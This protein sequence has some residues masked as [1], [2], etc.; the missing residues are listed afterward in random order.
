MQNRQLNDFLVK[1]IAVCVFALIL[2]LAQAGGADLQ[3]TWADNSAD[4]GGFHIERREATVAAYSR[5]ATVPPNTTSYTD[6]G[7]SDGKSFC[8]R[9]DAFNNSG[10]SPYSDEVCGSTPPG[11]TPLSFKAG[12]TI[13]GS[14]SVASNPAGLN[15][16]DKCQAIFAAGST[17]TLTATPASSSYFAGWTGDDDCI[18]GTIT[19]NHDTFCTAVFRSLPTDLT[20]TINIVEQAST[21]GKGTGKVVSNPAGIDCGSVCSATFSPRSSIVLKAIAAT[22]SV[23]AGWSGDADCA[24]GT[25]YLR[26]NRNCT[27]TFRLSTSTLTVTRVGSGNGSVTSSTSGID[28]GT[29]CTAQF[30]EGIVVK[31]TATPVADSQFTGWSGDPDCLDGAITITGSKT[32]TAAFTLKAATATMGIYRPSSGEIFLI[33]NPSGTWQGCNI[34]YCVTSPANIV[35]LSGDWNGTGKSSLAMYDPSRNNW[36]LDSNES[37]TWQGCDQ[38]ECISFAAPKAPGN[39]MQ[40]PIVGSWNGTG[41]DAVGIVEYDPKSVDRGRGSRANGGSE[42]GALWYLDK[43]DNGQFDGCSVD[44]CSGPFGAANTLPVAG[45]WDGGKTAKIGVFNPADG[46]WQLDMNDNGVFDG[47]SVDKCFGPFGTSNDMPVAGDWTG[48]GIAKIGVFRATTGEWFLDKNGNGKWDGPAIDQ[49]L[50]NFGQEGD[51]PLV[52]KW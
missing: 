50:S 40:I 4:E 7:L 42:A 9:I 38:D 24:D 43:N 29:L 28:C 21:A 48:D 10:Q 45:S 3:L 39:R 8:Y 49:Y 18:D 17:L 15:C 19:V 6:T 23:F 35:A 34:D 14:G 12:V 51:L 11:Q 46:T 2:P 37:F 33:G 25:V 20:L 41:K 47:C 32:C 44:Q 16:I 27:A 31:L 26:E 5:I 13:M 1:I 22:G 36:Q 52:G 30:A